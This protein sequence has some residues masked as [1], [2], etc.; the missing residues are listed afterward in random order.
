MTGFA[1]AVGGVGDV[2]WTWELKSVNG[3]SLD[4]RCRLPAPLESLEPAVRS[5]IQERFKRG[6]IVAALN[7]ARPVGAVRLRLNQDVVDQLEDIIEAMSIRVK[8]DTP[9]L[10]GLLGIKGVI[11][12]V[13]EEESKDARAARE[14]AVL[15]SLDEAIDALGRNRAAE[16]ERLAAVLQGHLAAAAA[17]ADRAGGAA[18]LQPEAIKARLETQ[19]TSLLDSAPGLPAERLAQEAA[20]L[21]AK[22]DVREELDRLCAHLAAAR[23]LL[24]EGGAIGRRLDFLCQEL[25]REANTICSKSTDMDLTRAGLDLKSVIDQLREQVQ[26][27]E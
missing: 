18:A 21:A 14:A 4:V 20:L 17:A 26:N 19:V 23:D 3:R 15:A 7:L 22:A 24:S 5:R 6:S 16:G 25:N 13:E 8:A 12:T 27:I 2:G 9:R 10:D 1:S 11:E